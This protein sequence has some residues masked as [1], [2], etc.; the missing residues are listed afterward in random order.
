M[1]HTPKKPASVSQE[2]YD[3]G[4]AGTSSSNLGAGYSNL[5]S[6]VITG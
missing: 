6:A 3:L 1:T 2:F 4:Y 5:A